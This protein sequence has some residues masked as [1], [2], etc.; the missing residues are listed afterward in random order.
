MGKG[1]REESRQGK[2]HW[3]GGGG[4]GR[5]RK[6][7]EKVVWGGEG[8]VRKRSEKEVGG[9]ESEERYSKGG[10]GRGE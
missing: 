2:G 6:G 7:S 8:R 3:K 10:G 4:E 5:V 9:G 1:W